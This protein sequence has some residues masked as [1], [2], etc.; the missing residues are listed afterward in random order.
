MH[1]DYVYTHILHCFIVVKI[2][3]TKFTILNH[4]FW[5]SHM[6]KFPGPEIE[7]MPQQ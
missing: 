1:L 7:P 5:P 6:Q 3:N 2:Y 4:F